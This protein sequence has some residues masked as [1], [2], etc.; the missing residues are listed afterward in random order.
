MMTFPSSYWSITLQSVSTSQSSV[1]LTLLSS[2]LSHST[3]KSKLILHIP[4]SV[5][6]LAETNNGMV[7]DLP[8]QPEAVNLPH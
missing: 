6:E 5:M 7:L 4:D 8:A 3:A 2:V 1:A